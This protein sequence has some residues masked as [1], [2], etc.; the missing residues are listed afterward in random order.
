MFVLLND[1]Y[2]IVCTVYCMHIVGGGRFSQKG[3][4]AT[5]N[6]LYLSNYLIFLWPLKNPTLQITILKKAHRHT[7][8]DNRFF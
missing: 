2:S 8:L 5:V 6:F 4:Y 3:N 1:P 7:F